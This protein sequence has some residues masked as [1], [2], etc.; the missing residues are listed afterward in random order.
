MKY[1]NIRLFSL[2]IAIFTF[3]LSYYFYNAS[4]LQIREAKEHLV[5]N[6][7][8][9]YL[10]QVNN[11]K[12]NA[13]FGGVFV[14]PKDSLEPNK[15]LKN[16]TLMTH[17][18]RELIKV[19]PAWMTRQLSEVNDNI[20]MKFH[21]VSLN[22]LNPNNK[23]QGF[24]E[25]ALEYVEKNRLAS[26]YEIDEKDRVVHYI[27]ALLVTQNCLQCHANQ[28]YKLGDYRGGISFHASAESFLDLKENLMFRRSVVIIILSTFALG[29]ILLYRN[30]VIEKQTLADKVKS[31][32]KYLQ[33]ILDA[34]EDILI[35]TTGTELIDANNS[36]MEILG[37]QNL[38]S[39][40]EEYQ[41]LCELFIE[42]DEP[43][44]LLNDGTNQWLIN[45]LNNRN[46]FHKVLIK[47]NAQHHVFKV[48][49]QELNAEDEKL[50]LAQFTDITYVE[51]EQK[52]LRDIAHKDALT[53]LANRYIFDEFLKNTILECSNSKISFSVV[54]IDID[55]FKAINDTYGH[56]IGDN[57]LVEIAKLLSDNTR[58]GDLVSRWGGEEFF[59]IVRGQGKEVAA[60]LAEKIRK[61]IDIHH[62]D[63]VEHLTCSF[64]VVESGYQESEESIL[65]RAD[66]EL[67][68][69]KH[70]GKNQVSVG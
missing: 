70:N 55:N 54:M 5:N 13:Q 24:D 67:Y 53:G 57:V 19:N 30:L 22:P 45:V 27:G 62:F 4:N 60:R 12:W 50:Y 39:F 21:I 65:K 49:V 42:N 46:R 69:A 38:D 48:G 2:F 10:S 25:R 40:K 15:Y 20:N 34:N 66:N 26:Y 3:F 9:Q 58:K 23:A 35:I 47:I 36:F 28:G 1:P 43:D 29:M 56:D 14:L 68:R 31:R 59:I 6:L 8:M 16:N 7:E 33:S 61:I 44:Y 63:Q 51:N 17:D 18:G 37:Y 32:T 41:C 64:G 11:R 52:L